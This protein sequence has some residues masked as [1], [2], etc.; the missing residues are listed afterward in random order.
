MT[1]IQMELLVFMAE[2][3]S[4]QMIFWKNHFE[5]K[6]KLDGLIKRVKEEKEYYYN[7]ECTKS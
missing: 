1:K 6:Q 4:E 5:K 7:V 2:L 3:V